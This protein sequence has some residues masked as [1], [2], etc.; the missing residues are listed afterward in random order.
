MKKEI[1]GVYGASGFGREVM[2]IARKSLKEQGK[3]IEDLF[4]IDDNPEDSFVNGHRVYTYGEFQSLQASR[5]FVSIAISD[6]ALR[7]KLSSRL[8]KD[9]FLPL[10]LFA[11]GS[12]VMDQVQIGEG[13]ILS[14]HVTLTSNIKIGK[15]FQA[16]IY[17][18]VAHDCVIGDFVTLA[19]RVSV[20][21]NIHIEDHAYIGTG[22]VIRQGTSESPLVIGKGAIIGMGAVVLKSVKPGTIV[23]GNPAKELKR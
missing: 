15:Y 5:K 12:V 9:G 21:G 6:A 8:K 4:F 19:P 14:P 7:E 3:N 20:N 17:S 10:S 16:N 22:A 1:Y 11:E 2:P 13:A 23:I 18:Y